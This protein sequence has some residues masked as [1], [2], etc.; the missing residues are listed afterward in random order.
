[1]QPQ[2]PAAHAAKLGSRKI[3]FCAVQY[4]CEA[5]DI[6]LDLIGIEGSA[7]KKSIRP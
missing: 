2:P 1:M 3:V 7:I 6:A 5:G 4:L